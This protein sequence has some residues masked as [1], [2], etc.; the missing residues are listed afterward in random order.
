MVRVFV[1]GAYR[2]TGNRERSVEKTSSRNIF[3]T[4]AGKVVRHARHISLK[5]YSLDAG[6]KL[7]MYALRKLDKYLPCRT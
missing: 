3:Y 6:A 1:T 2:G 7:L 5:I 4:L